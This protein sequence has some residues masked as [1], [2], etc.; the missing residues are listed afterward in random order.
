[1][2]KKIKLGSERFRCTEL[3]FQPS[4]RGLDIGGVQHMMYQTIQSCDMDIRKD[5]IS[6]VVITGG[7]TCIEGFESRLVKELSALSNSNV[8]L[9]TND[10]E[11]SVFEGGVILANLISFREHWITQEEYEEEGPSIVHRKCN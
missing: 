10:K 6:N 1:M 8:K 3:L 5:L 4:V 11:F 2:V 9:V 7:T